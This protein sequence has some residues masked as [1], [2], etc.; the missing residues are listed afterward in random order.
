[1]GGFMNYLNKFIPL[2]NLKL[3]HELVSIDSRARELRFANGHVTQYDGLVSSVALPDLIRIIQGAP[4]DVVKAS[5][6]LACST[7]VLVNI[8]VNR[9]GLSKAHLTYFYDEYICFS[10]LGFPHMLTTRNAPAG[11]GSIQA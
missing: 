5:Q 3:N 8:G 7:C 9:E 6:L 11:T 2:G 1:A 4:P 10:R